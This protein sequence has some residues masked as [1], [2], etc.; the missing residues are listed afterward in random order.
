MSST[1]PGSS[2]YGRLERRCEI[3]E[4]IPREHVGRT[5]YRWCPSLLSSPYLPPDFF[6]DF[7]CLES[8]GERRL[9]PEQEMPAFLGRAAL[10]G[11]AI[12]RAKSTL[13]PETVSTYHVMRLLFQLSSQ[14][15]E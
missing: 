8:A 4:P 13:S 7:I 14:L 3:S 2:Q 1:Q 9:I 10:A 12:L 5:C 6:V 11:L 15:R